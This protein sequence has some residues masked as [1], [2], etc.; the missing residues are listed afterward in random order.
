MLRLTVSGLSIALCWA[1]LSAFWSH[2]A[3]AEG[4]MAIGVTGN[5]AKDGYSLGIAVN[6]ATEAIAREKALQWCRT[7]G[8]ARTRDRCKIFA[9]FHDQCAAEAEDPA[10]G[11]PGAGWAVAK[12][13]AAAK[14]MAMANCVATAGKDRASFCKVVNF[15]CDGKH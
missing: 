12:D 13:E 8:G 14:K 15:A 7:H 11:T 4:A 6:Q 9:A 1:L 3:A 2:Q 10:A 5:I